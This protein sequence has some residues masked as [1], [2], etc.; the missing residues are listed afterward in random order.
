[1]LSFYLSVCLVC[2]LVLHASCLHNIFLE[3]FVGSSDFL[4]GLVMTK[5]LYSGF[6]FIMQAIPHVRYAPKI[7]VIE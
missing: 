7:G 6:L 4:L 3:Q 5:F 2:L 1:M